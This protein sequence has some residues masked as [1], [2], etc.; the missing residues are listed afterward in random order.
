MQASNTMMTG[1]EWAEA[2]CQALEAMGFER[3]DAQSLAEVQ[4]DLE[5]QLYRQGVPAIVAAKRLA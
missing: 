4:E 2:M 3:S 5:N 1:L